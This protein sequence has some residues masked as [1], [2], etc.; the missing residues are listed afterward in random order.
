M[1][2]YFESWKYM[3]LR[4][5]LAQ[6]KYIYYFVGTFGGLAPPPPNTKKLA[7]LVGGGVGYAFTFLLLLKYVI[8]PSAVSTS[9]F[10]WSLTPGHAPD[11]SP[12]IA[13]WDFLMRVSL[14]KNRNQFEMAPSV[15]LNFNVT[16]NKT[17]SKE[18][19]DILFMSRVNW[20][21][22]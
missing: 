10:S 6:Y 20:I 17:L 11:G 21:E 16:K 8:S 1:Q 14:C 15:N 22:Q 18:Y 19:M 12:F 3:F 4:R 7:T 9:T 13:R 5:S 2:M